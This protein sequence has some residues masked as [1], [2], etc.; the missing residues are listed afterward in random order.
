MVIDQ[1]RG[2]AFAR[3]YRHLDVARARCGALVVNVCLVFVNSHLGPYLNW[4]TRIPSSEPA[5]HGGRALR[6]I[7]DRIA[8]TQFRLHDEMQKI[9]Q[10]DLGWPHE[11][12]WR[13]P[14]RHGGTI[15]TAAVVMR[16]NQWYC[17]AAIQSVACKQIL[18]NLLHNLLLNLRINCAVEE[19]QEGLSKRLSKRL[20]KGAGK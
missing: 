14:E 9:R 12:E 3:G 13:R 11:V 8:G 6:P 7:T 18:I 19:K 10:L 1:A 2:I 4:Q 15:P 5:R 17:I 16:N 20:R